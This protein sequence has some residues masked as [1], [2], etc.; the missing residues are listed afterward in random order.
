M[1]SSAKRA[2]RIL[3]T[4]GAA[5][6][7]A[8]V[9][10]VARALSLSPG[11]VFRSLDA[12]GK[13]GLV[14]RYQASA[15]YV[16]GPAAERLRHSLIACFRMRDVCLPYLRQLASVSGETTSLHVRLGWYGVR[17]A[18]VPGTGEVTNSPPLGE[19]HPLG[20]RYSGEAILAFLSENDIAH[21]RV[22][23]AKHGVRWSEKQRELG[24][25]RSQ[26]FAAGETGFGDGMAVALPVRDGDAALAGIAIEG[27]VFNPQSP[28]SGVSGWSEIVGHVEALARA[29]PQLFQNPFAHLDPD[30]I[31]LGD[32]PEQGSAG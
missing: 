4:V 31:A 29:Q 1:S 13:A 32:L 8:G 7:P 25:I 6:N 12:L 26:G 23:A 5:E 11:T 24:A 10:E 17:I 20:D 14:T 15:R 28:V 19:A 2:L 16:L 3:E 27:P 18:S 22:W 30:T 21:Y 9:S